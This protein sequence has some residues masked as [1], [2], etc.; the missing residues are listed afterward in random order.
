[1]LAQDRGE[2]DKARQF[3]RQADDWFRQQRAR[4]VS[5]VPANHDWARMGSA[6]R[7]WREAVRKL[8]SPRIAE[9]DALLAKEPQNAAARLERAQLLAAAD[10]PE[11]ALADLTKAGEP[12]ANSVEY[13]GLRGRIFAR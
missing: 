3:L 4:P 9:L 11:E 5:Q 8:A 12:A 13:L 10:L 6:W 2:T 1:M 7:P